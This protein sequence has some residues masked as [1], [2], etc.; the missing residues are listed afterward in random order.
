MDNKGFARLLLVWIVADGMVGVV[1]GVLVSIL[2]ARMQFL[3]AVANTLA[4]NQIIASLS[5]RIA[6]RCLVANPVQIIHASKEFHL[7]Q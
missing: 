6:V 2:T 5:R 3:R 7:H 4:L 1:L